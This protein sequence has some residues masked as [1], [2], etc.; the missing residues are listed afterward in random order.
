MFNSIR[1]WLKIVIAKDELDYLELAI[2]ERSKYE[3]Q[4]LVLK[5]FTEARITQKSY[6]TFC[7]ENRKRN[8]NAYWNEGLKGRADKFGMGVLKEYVDFYLP[9]RF[10]NYP[11]GRAWFNDVYSQNYKLAISVKDKLYKQCVK[12][13]NNHL[14]V[15]KDEFTKQPRQKPTNT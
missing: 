7:K 12:A 15:S 14:R 4:Y 2:K 13:S 11:E 8:C 6:L 3:Y 1:K 9:V 5:F 10:S